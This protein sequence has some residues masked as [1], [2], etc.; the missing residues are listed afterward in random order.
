MVAV[1]FEVKNVDVSWLVGEFPLST[2][3]AF[4]SELTIVIPYIGWRVPFVW[5]VICAIITV[6]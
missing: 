1:I 3:S 4:L 6:V 5:A 2:T